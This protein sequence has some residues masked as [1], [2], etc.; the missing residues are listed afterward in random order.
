ML[1][2]AA[3]V[4]LKVLRFVVCDNTNS[5]LQAIASNTEEQD[6]KF[7]ALVGAM[8]DLLAAE[9]E[10][11]EMKQKQLNMKGNLVAEAE[12]FDFDFDSIASK[13]KG[14]AI[15]IGSAAKTLLC[16]SSSC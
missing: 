4:A 3:P 1:L 14:T 11:K 6:A 9:E 15:K 12:L 8:G 5:Q 13:L 7:M 2:S 10:L 16:N